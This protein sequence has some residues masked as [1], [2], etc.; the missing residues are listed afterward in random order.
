MNEWILDAVVVE[1]SNG[2]SFKVSTRHINVLL[3]VEFINEEKTSP[4]EMFSRLRPWW[5]WQEATFETDHRCLKRNAKHALKALFSWINPV[6]EKNM[7]QKCDS[8][9]IIISS[10]L[11]HQALGLWSPRFSLQGETCYYQSN[12]TVYGAI[13]HDWSGQSWH[14]APHTLRF[15][16]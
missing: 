14:I 10:A 3:L 2:G 13:W 4:S 5:M 9:M 6:A 15:D 16:W 8:E 1:G 7:R 11:L 12:L